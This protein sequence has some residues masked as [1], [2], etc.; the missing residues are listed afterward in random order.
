VPKIDYSA[1]LSAL[2]LPLLFW[3]G[4]VLTITLMGYPGIICMTPL[5]WLLA[6]PVGLRVYRE[7][8]SPGTR[9][10]LEAALGGGLLGFWQG[11]LVPSVMAVSRYLPGQGLPDPPNSIFAAL[12]ATII[13]IPAAAGLAAL[14]TWLARRRSSQ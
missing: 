13:S 8:S 9:P 5:A 1:I 12:L 6:L 2:F 4:S 3:T 10:V 11:M 7:S 14:I